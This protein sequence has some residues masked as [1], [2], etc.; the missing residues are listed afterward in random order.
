[1]AAC[2]SDCP[3]NGAMTA[4]L[5]PPYSLSSGISV[6]VAA[7][8]GEPLIHV[9]ETAEC[10]KTKTV[11]FTTVGVALTHEEWRELAKYR[12]ELTTGLKYAHG[13]KKPELN[14]KLSSMTSVSTGIGY[15][16]GSTIRLFQFID[17]NDDE[18]GGFNDEELK[19]PC[20]EISLWPNAWHQ[21][22]NSWSEIDELIESVT[23]AA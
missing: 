17:D 4:V 13:W 9:R 2:P 7:K 20:A 18:D 1:M 16:G 3:E 8:D 12:I 10:F 19:E 15:Q 6:W 23:I 21:L 14:R 22:T 5:A 11:I